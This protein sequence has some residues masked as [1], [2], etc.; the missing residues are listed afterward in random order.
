ME[1]GG[2]LVDRT[3]LRDLKNV[4]KQFADNEYIHKIR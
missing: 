2:N 3:V 1:M 4:K